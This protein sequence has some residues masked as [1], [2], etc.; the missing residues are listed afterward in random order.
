M[1]EAIT[2]SV[3]TTGPAASRSTTLGVMMSPTALGMLT[4][5]PCVSTWATTLYVVPRSMPIARPVGAF[6]AAAAGAAAELA[7]VGWAR[8]A[9]SAGGGAGGAAI[10]AAG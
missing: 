5:R 6:A 3:P 2:A 7:G 9:V 8:G 4:G 1:A 10:G